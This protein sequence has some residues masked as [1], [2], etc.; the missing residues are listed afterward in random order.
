MQEKWESRAVP[1]MKAIAERESAADLV[2]IPDIAQ[3]AA[4]DPE[5]VLVELSR[6]VNAGYVD[7]EVQIAGGGAENAH[8]LNPVLSERGARAVGLWPSDDPYEALM[9]L[10]E[11]QLA[12][13]ADTETKTKLQKLREALSEIG[14]G[15]ASGLLV[16][17]IQAGA[18]LH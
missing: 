5:A 12:E 16:A 10:I 13:E 1:I 4:L 11:K 14:K 17:L 3:E 8:L 18:H 7:G 6:L 9:A 2:M 15:T